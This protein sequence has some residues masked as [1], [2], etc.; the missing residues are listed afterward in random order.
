MIKAL[1]KDATSDQ[2]QIAHAF[3]NADFKYDFGYTAFH[4]AV[5]NAY[6]KDDEGR[7]S[8]L[9]LLQCEEEGSNAPAGQNWREF[10][11]KY[12]GRSPLFAELIEE[13]RSLKAGRDHDPRRRHL[14]LIDKGDDRQGWTPFHWAA[15]TGRLEEMKHLIA[16]GADPFL[17]TK[18]ERNSLHQAAESK[19]PEI[20]EYVLSLP[21]YNGQ[22]FNINKC[23]R[24]G[25]PPLYVAVEGSVECVKMLLDRGAKRD[26]Q[27]HDGKVALHLASLSKG[28]ERFEIVKILTADEGPHINRQD[29]EGIPPLFEMLDTPDCVALLLERGASLLLRDNKGMTAIHHACEENQ[30]ASLKLLLNE[31]DA[32][33]A[34]A[35]DDHKDIPLAKAFEFKSAACIIALLERNAIGDMNT[36]DGTILAHRA[37]QMG[38]A[39]VLECV[40]DHWTFKKGL[41]DRQGRTVEEV[42]KDAGTYKDKVKDLI[43]LYESKGTRVDKNGKGRVLTAQ[44]PGASTAAA[45]ARMA[46]FSYK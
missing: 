45:E 43:L 10:K 20:M 39:E 28:P 17:F 42:A 22:W 27:D 18:Q 30:A 14:K 24:W 8:L 13:F 36:K 1:H 7:P 46:Y 44:Y 6:D 2:R 23:D 29:N 35:A 4:I 9:E 21:E 37:A 26:I 16:H 40:F 33:L 41:R 38:N 25:H 31:C 11:Q 12:C 3:K 5:L 34:V 15:Y 32:D 19:R